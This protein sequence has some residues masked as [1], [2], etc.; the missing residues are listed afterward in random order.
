MKVLAICLFD[1][2]FAIGSPALSAAKNP[3]ARGRN[4]KQINK[5]SYASPIT[6]IHGRGD[7]KYAYVDIANDQ[8]ICVYLAQFLPFK[9]K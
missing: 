3:F 9:R 7:V 2:S 4:N 1:I 8:T 6:T 5:H